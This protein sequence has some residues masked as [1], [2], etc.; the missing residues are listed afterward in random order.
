MAETL[1]ALVGDIQKFSTQDGPG[2]RSTVFLKGCPLKCAWCHNPEM[3]DP[4]QQMIISPSRCIGCGACSEACPENG[5]QIG[6][7]GPAIDFHACRACGDCA[8]VCFAKAITPVAGEMTVEEIMEKV[9]QDREFYENSGGGVT[10]S[11]GELLLHSEFA[12]ALTDACA[13]EGIKVCLDTCGYGDP[14][15]LMELAARENVEY[16]LYDI[17]HM[18]P[19]EHKKLTGVGNGQILSNLKMLSADPGICHKIWIRMPLIKNINDGDETIAQTAELMKQLDIHRVT[20][21]PYHDMGNAKAKNTGAKYYE[22]EAPSE[23]RIKEIEKHF[24][25]GEVI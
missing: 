20:L 12:A 7:N 5:I 23:S 18:D 19:E 2:I 3:I 9:L 13:S 25:E 11:G 8:S 6:E 21:L 10:I 1:K 17:K 14:D 24:R 4:K 15:K 16:V 22:F